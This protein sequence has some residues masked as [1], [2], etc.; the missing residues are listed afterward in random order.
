MK[1]ITLIFSVLLILFSLTVFMTAS[2][3]A[4]VRRCDATYEWQTTGGTIGP[5]SFGKFTAKGEC[6]STAP[7][8]CRDRA[9]E[10]AQRCIGTQWER[11]WQ[12]YEFNPD[13]FDSNAPEACLEAANIE[14]YDLTTKCDKRKDNFDPKAICHKNVNKSNAIPVTVARKGDIKAALEA[15]VC[16]IFEEGKYQFPNNEDVHVR[17]SAHTW[18]NSGNKRCRSNQD[19]S[20]DYKIDCTRVRKSVCQS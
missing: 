19:L 17:L 11:R 4:A 7:N 1:R 15:R 13:G 5:K 16:C 12:H 2:A 18:S 8:N 20:S 6:G 14:D 10:A 3:S 9:R